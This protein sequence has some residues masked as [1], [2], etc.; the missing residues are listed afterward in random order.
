MFYSGWE[1]SK[2]A[3]ITV[4]SGYF[5][6][7]SPGLSPRAKSHHLEACLDNRV[8]SPVTKTHV[9]YLRYI[10]T[11]LL[12]ETLTFYAHKWECPHINDKWLPLKL[13]ASHW[14]PVALIRRWLS[15]FLWRD[16]WLYIIVYVRIHTINTSGCHKIKKYK[17]LHFIFSWTQSLI[18]PL[19]SLQ[20]PNIIFQPQVATT[21]GCHK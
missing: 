16:H 6:L 4:L 20:W 13:V 1:R 12:S 18:K 2:S 10:H 7:G 9:Y 21:C 8:D 14:F 5:Y 3:D 17:K 19:V 11:E 15:N